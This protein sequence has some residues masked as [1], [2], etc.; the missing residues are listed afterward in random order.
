MADN[1]AITA[2]TGTTIATD[3]VAAN[4]GSIGHVQ[5][6][7]LVDGTS[8]G[9]TGLPGDANG[10][11]TVPRRDLIETSVTS[12]GLTI[13]TTSYTAGDQMGT[14]FSVT[15]AGRANGGTGYI[16]GVSL[17]SAQDAIGAVDVVFFD[18]NV[19]LAGDNALF[20]ISDPDAL[21]FIGLVQLSGAYDIGN[22]RVAQAY[23]LAIPYKCDAA[24]T[25]IF[26]ALIT[27]SAHTFFV[28]VTDLQLNVF[29]ER[30]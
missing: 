25:S 29:M 17:I 2:G 23:N 12:G 28:A 13:A 14:M 5:Y 3:E 30:N 7:K 15:N 24:T 20:A 10:L 22:N 8:N 6:V 27:R 16:T 18:T 9:T 1:V 19:T 11:Y 21:K 26:A 4:G